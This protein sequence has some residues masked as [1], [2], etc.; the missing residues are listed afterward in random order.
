MSKARDLADFIAD[1][2]VATAEIA[3]GAVTAGKLNVTG[4]GTLGQALT[5]DADGS[6]SWTTITSDLVDDATP[7]LG[8]NLDLNGSDITG[9]GNVNVTGTITA[10]NFVGS[11]LVNDTTPQLGGALDTNGNDIN[12]GDNDKAQFGAS[13]DLQIYHTSST[14]ESYIK[15]SGTGNFFIQGTNIRLQDTLGNHYLTAQ[16]GGELYLYHNGLQKVQVN[17][18]GI[19]VTG[20]VTADGVSLGD[21]E[22][23][24][25]GASNDLEIYHS[26]THSEIVDTGTGNLRIRADDLRVQTADGNAS[27]IRGTNAGSVQLYHNGLEKLAT[28]SSGVSV[29]GTVAATAFTG[30]GSALTGLPGGGGSFYRMYTGSYSN[31]GGSYVQLNFTNADTSK[32][33]WVDVSIPASYYLVIQ[34]NSASNGSFI[35]QGSYGSNIS[36][37]S[38][39]I[40]LSSTPSTTSSINP[41]NSGMRVGFLPTSSTCSFRFTRT[42]GDPG[43]TAYF[44]VHH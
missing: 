32:V 4:D 5:S 13:N 30:D 7:Q 10:T 24:Q 20:T 17:T 33:I 38:V 21:N 41:V 43:A 3:D 2:T 1:S 25:F 28:T 36:S 29:T 11:D 31:S 8:G 34:A 40:N 42:A 12:F 35:S 27:Y 19:D 26:G 22:K 23:A 39:S 18:S 14:G 9:T 16:S 15:E 44:S 6:F 37:A